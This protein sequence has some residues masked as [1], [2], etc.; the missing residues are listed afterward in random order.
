MARVHL[1]TFRATYRGIFADDFLAGLTETGMA[2]RFMGVMEDPRAFALVAEVAGRVVGL[3]YAGP[4]RYFGFPGGEVRALYVHPA[5][6]GKG[7]G[8]ALFEAATDRLAAAGYDRV[9]IFVV[10]EN[11]PARRFYER[12]GTRLAGARL[13]SI[14]T[15]SGKGL[16][17]VAY[18]KLL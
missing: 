6:Q 9:W 13:G 11:A 15:V 16:C 2:A 17:L 14:P 1:E 18:E 8:R 4:S 7:H 10:S 3:A 12:L 5:H